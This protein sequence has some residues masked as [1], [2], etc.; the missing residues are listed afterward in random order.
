MMVIKKIL[1][2]NVIITENTAGHEV[3]AMGCGIAFKKKIG[4]AV[5]DGSIDKVYTLS[6][7]GMLEKFKVLL[8]DLSMDYLE[9]SNEIIDL[10]EKELG[11]RLNESVYISLTDHL[12]M[13]V[14][15]FNEGLLIRNMMLWE[16]RRFYTKEFGIGQ[17]AIQVLKRKFGVELPE[18]E[19][20]FIALHIIDGQMDIEQPL[21][22]HIMHLIQEITNIVRYTTKTEYDKDSLQYYRFITHLKFFAKR[23]F[24]GQ[25]NPAEVDDEM[26]EM[27][28]KKY[29]LAHLCA[30]KISEF[31]EQ[32]YQYKVSAD[33]KFYLMI[34]VAKVIRQA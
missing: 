27:V 11:R 8:A 4:D 31:V 24:T 18:D 29:A 17:K 26:N 25:E 16:I 2:N 28:Q 5:P 23:I 15:R 34:H 12:H 19:A 32:N 33:E 14:Q 13:A 22:N 1:N 30:E 9:A 20:G 6:D 7:Q 21:A 3:V 10:A